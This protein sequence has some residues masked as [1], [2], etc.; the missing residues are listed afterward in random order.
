MDDR[1]QT[2]TLGLSMLGPT[3][4]GQV[5]ILFKPG[6]SINEVAAIFR[7]TATVDSSDADTKAQHERLARTVDRLI[8][9]CTASGYL[10]RL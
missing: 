6:R 1:Y 4:I 3:D 2:T 5:L 9:Q 8:L 10:Q 7:E